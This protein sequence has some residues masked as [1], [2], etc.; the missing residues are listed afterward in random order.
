MTGEPIGMSNVALLLGP[1]TFQSFEIPASINFGGAQR[2]VIHRLPGGTRVIDALGRDDSDISFSGIFSGYDATV[3]ARVIDEIRVAGLPV[4]LTWDILFYTVIIKKFEADYRSGWWIPYRV[5]CMVVLDQASSVVATVISLADGASSDVATALGLATTAA[6][7]LSKTQSAVNMPG[8][9]V[10]GT[11]PNSSALVA[12]ANAR[13][14]L[15][16]GISEAA[17]TLGAPAWSSDDQMQDVTSTFN[18]IV[19]AAQQ[20][21]SLTIAQAYIG[22]AYTNLTN[23]S[24]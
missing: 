13:A 3:R 4:P 6:I 2:L 19:S 9:T 7:D 1:V 14:Q 12:L 18:G 16:T 8:A 23:A 24:T 21:S 10:R 20:I 17:L 5:T 11:A 22:R 15:G